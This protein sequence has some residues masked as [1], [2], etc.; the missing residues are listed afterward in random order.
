MLAL[1]RGGGQRGRSR[2]EIAERDLRAGL[3]AGGVVQALRRKGWPIRSVWYRG[4]DRDGRAV[5]WV[6]Y[7]LEK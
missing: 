1:I 4:R 6:R 2:L 3:G 7:K 5:R